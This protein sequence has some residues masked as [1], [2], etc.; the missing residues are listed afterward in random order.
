[1]SQKKV[2]PFKEGDI[3]PRS[4]TAQQEKK[5]RE[6]KK[7]CGGKGTKRR[8]KL[9]VWRKIG[10]WGPTEGG[11]KAPSGP[12]FKDPGREKGG[13]KGKQQENPGKKGENTRRG[14]PPLVHNFSKKGR[15]RS[16]SFKNGNLPLQ[17]ASPR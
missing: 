1:M 13:G 15:G 6:S 8:W 17:T 12:V 7:A 16:K 2:V 14:R 10:V 9:V 11:T 3:D 4:W 5:E